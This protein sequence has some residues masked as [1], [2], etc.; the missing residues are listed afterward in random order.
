LAGDRRSCGHELR[1]AICRNDRLMHAARLTGGGTHVA[2]V[3]CLSG[4]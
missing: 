4:R 3:G 2:S 1:Q